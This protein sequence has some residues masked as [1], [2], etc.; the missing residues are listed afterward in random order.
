MLGH[1]RWKVWTLCAFQCPVGT[2][3]F[4]CTESEPKTCKV[5]TKRE[6]KPC[7]LSSQDITKR[8]S[9]SKMFVDSAS[10]TNRENVQNFLQCKVFGSFVSIAIRGSSKSKSKVVAKEKKFE[11]KRELTKILEKEIEKLIERMLKTWI[12][13]QEW[14]ELWKRKAQ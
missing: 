4:P 2:E 5:S 1:N 8:S 7:A 14:S 11:H 10:A 3:R 9:F 13:Y 12:V 6:I